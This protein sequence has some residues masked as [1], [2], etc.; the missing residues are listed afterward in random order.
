MLR[1]YAQT[2]QAANNEH[3]LEEAQ[4]QQRR[5][6]VTGANGFVGARL[7][8]W[9]VDREC[10]VVAA[11]R[12]SS[13]LEL[14]DGLEQ[15]QLVCCELPDSQPLREVLDSSMTVIHCAASRVDAPDVESQRRL[16]EVNVT[17]TREV[18]ECCRQ[19]GVPTH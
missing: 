1:H 5:F 19:A 15:L 9:L 7:C 4:L 10:Q 13:S 2:E 12:S 6:L 16:F 3:F 11:V 8:R 18:V 14:L 17:G